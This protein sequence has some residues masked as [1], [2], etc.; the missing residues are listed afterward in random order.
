MEYIKGCAVCQ[1]SK[2]LMH[3]KHVPLYH[4]LTEENMPPFQ[5]VAMD[6]ITGL[7]TQKGL[8]AILTIID[9]RCS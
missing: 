9:H 1:Q 7:P 5:V 8:D 6:L 2:I 3:R 4:I